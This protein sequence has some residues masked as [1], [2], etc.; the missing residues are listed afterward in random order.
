M[1][2]GC[3]LQEKEEVNKGRIAIEAKPKKGL[4]QEVELRFKSAAIEE[5]T[6]DY[7]AIAEGTQC[8]G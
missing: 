8:C 7:C 3:R 6:K 2:C 1:L 5:G 4:I